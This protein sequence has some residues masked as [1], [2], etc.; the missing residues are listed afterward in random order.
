[1]KLLTLHSSESVQAESAEDIGQD[2]VWQVA[3]GDLISKGTLW[4][5]RM[6]DSP[7]HRCVSN[8]IFACRSSPLSFRLGAASRGFYLPFT[9]SCL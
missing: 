8:F 5:A 1:M 6:G 9:S 4:C 2:V 3:Q 7:L